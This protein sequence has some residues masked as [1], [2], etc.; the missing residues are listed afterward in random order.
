M[1]YSPIFHF[2]FRPLA[3]TCMRMHCKRSY[4]YLEIP[5]DSSCSSDTKL[6]SSPRK[7]TVNPS[8]G[9]PAPLPF[10]MTPP[11][12]SKSAFY[13]RLFIFQ[14]LSTNQ[15]GGG[16]R[17]GRKRDQSDHDVECVV[18]VFRSSSSRSLPLPPFCPYEESRFH[19]V[20]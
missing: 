5:S 16:W 19:L 3:D 10:L 20:C 15:K 4:S 18:S 17:G 6:D 8:P 2:S 11:P 7:T 9:S 13:W 14:R 12:V 1:S